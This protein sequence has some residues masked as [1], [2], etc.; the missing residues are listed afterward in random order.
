[1]IRNLPK[2]ILLRSV[3]INEPVRWVDGEAAEK[4]LFKSG[5][6]EAPPG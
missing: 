1:M 2:V 5:G 3:E 4:W 6:P